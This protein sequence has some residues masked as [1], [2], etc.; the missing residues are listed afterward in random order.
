VSEPGTARLLLTEVL[1]LPRSISN[2]VVPYNISLGQF[3]GG[4]GEIIA[5]PGQDRGKG[6][7]GDQEEEEEEEGEVVDPHPHIY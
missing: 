2:H 7:Q 3:T 1:T 5:G 6:G 4:L